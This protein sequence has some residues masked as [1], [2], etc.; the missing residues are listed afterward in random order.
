MARTHTSLYACLIFAALNA[1]SLGTADASPIPPQITYSTEW[2]GPMA[3]VAGGSPVFEFKGVQNETAS[4][5]S[6]IKL[7]TVL[8]HQTSP[9]KGF[10]FDEDRVTIGFKISSVD[11]KPVNQSGNPLNIESRI[12]GSVY[13]DGTVAAGMVIQGVYNPLDPSSGSL[14]SFRVGA[15]TLALSPI[16]SDSG[17][18]WNLTPGTPVVAVDIY[19]ELN[20]APVPEPSVWL[21]FAGAALFARARNRR[22]K[23]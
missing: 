8:V 7:G 16:R 14:Q 13:E 11:G 22:A 3:G 15:L 20:A 5:G 6:V 1:L 9:E 17:R 10:T 12:G 18:L 4:L 21:I 2:P 19:M 23:H